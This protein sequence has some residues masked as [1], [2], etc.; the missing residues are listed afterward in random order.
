MQRISYYFRLF[1]SGYH[2]H[3][4]F[5]QNPCIRHSFITY[6]DVAQVKATT[7]KSMVGHEQG[8]VTHGVYTHYGIDHLQQFK[9]AIEKLPY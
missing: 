4:Q 7:I 9:E 3:N 5:F 2:L 8:T 6:L 1:V